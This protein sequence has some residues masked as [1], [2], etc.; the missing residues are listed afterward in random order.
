MEEYQQTHSKTGRK[1]VN[2]I[3]LVQAMNHKFHSQYINQQMYLI[4]R[5]S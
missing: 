4:K 3:Q 1:D 5:N 2:Q